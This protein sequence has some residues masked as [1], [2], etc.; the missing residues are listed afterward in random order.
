M[1][2]CSSIMLKSWFLEWPHVYPDY[3]SIM[4]QI[5]HVSWFAW[6][7][8]AIFSKLH[9]VV[10]NG[11]NLTLSSGW[12]CTVWICMLCLNCI[13]TR[14]GT[15]EYACYVW[16]VSERDLE[17]MVCQNYLWQFVMLLLVRGLK[18][19]VVCIFGAYVL[20]VLRQRGKSSIICEAIVELSNLK[21]CR[22]PK[23]Y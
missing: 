20:L 6:Y 16:I 17:L 13:G 7:K 23:F 8:L 10:T 5:K 18:D 21:C 19:E 12:P 11:K 2:V 15:D 22:D 4:S 14:F 3:N 9:N 1:C